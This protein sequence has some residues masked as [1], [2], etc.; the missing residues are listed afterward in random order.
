MSSCVGLVDRSKRV[1][2]ILR[3]RARDIELLVHYLV[4]PPGLEPG[5]TLL[6]LATYK[7]AALTIELWVHR[8]PDYRTDAER[9]SRLT[10]TV[11]NT[12]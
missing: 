5:F 1:P 6:G 10:L 12:S 9:C 11:T 3:N 4:H 8:A 7:D 2:N